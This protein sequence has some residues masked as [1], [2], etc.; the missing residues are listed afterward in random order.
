MKT[1]LYNYG[2]DEDGF[3]KR[4]DIPNRKLGEGVLDDPSIPKADGSSQEEVKE[5]GEGHDSQSTDLDQDQN[6]HLAE[7]GVEASRIHHDQPRHAYC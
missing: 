7:L 6:D 2:V 1:G 5:Y 4:I 3:Q